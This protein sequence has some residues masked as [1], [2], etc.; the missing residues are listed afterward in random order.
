MAQYMNRNNFCYN[1]QCSKNKKA[2]LNKFLLIT[3]INLQGY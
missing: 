2:K 3:I 1:I